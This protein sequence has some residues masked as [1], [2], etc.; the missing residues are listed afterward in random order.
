MAPHHG[1]R[2]A[3]TPELRTWAKPQ[4]VVSC[5]GQFLARN[6]P[7]CNNFFGTWP[8]GAITVRKDGAS[9]ILESFLTQRRRVLLGPT[10]A[11]GL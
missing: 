5:Q 6:R 3:N 4:V 7:H 8:D 1:S 2:T 9:W 11:G 10:P